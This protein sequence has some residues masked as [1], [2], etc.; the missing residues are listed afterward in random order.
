MGTI[1]GIV[2]VGTADGIAVGDLVGVKEG[3]IV[4]PAVGLAVVQVS[5]TAVGDGQAGVAVVQVQAQLLTP[6]L[7]AITCDTL[8]LRICT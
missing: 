1:D 8:L 6:L 7:E 5:V 2:V 3:L 4:G